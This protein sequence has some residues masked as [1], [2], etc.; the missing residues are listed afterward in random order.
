MALE[1]VEDLY[2]LSPTQAGM[3]YHSLADQEASVY[4]G[5]VCFLLE[6][7]LDWNLTIF[8]PTKQWH[9]CCHVLLKHN[10]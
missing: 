6:G 1:G 2:P 3:L 5:Q 9:Q 7:Q 4:T 10:I 8:L